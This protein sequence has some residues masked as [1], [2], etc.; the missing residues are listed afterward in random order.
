MRRGLSLLELVVA[1][2]LVSAVLLLV[3]NLFPQALATLSGSEF[4]LQAERL[5]QGE[6]EK[7][8]AAGFSALQPAQFQAGEYRVETRI[9][10]L[11]PTLREVTVTVRWQER[12][13]T[14][15]V[16]QHLRRVR[17]GT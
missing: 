6:V 8:M 9:D 7:A 4:R 2:S 5:A 16:V 10:S 1:M 11:S 15:S 12:G 3:L 13:R 17:H 14:R